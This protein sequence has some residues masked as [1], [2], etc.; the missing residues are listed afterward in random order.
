MGWGKRDACAIFVLEM[1]LYILEVL[2]T[3]TGLAKSLVARKTSMYLILAI[4]KIFI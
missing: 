3:R 4:S 2:F 1:S